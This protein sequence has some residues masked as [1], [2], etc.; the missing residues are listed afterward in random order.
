MKMQM[1]K[2]CLVH[3]ILLAVRIEYAYNMLY[4]GS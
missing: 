4:T 1:S 2:A 3:I